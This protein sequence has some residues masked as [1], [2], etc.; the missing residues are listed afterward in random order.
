MIKNGYCFILLV[1]AICSINQGHAQAPPLIDKAEKLNQ[2]FSFE[3]LYLHSDKNFYLAGEII[4]F[5]IYQINGNT[6]KVAYAEILD[7]NNKPVLQAKIPLT[8][9]GGNG[10]FYLPL[11]IKS[12]YYTLRAYTNWMKNAGNEIFFEKKISI[13][14]TMKALPVSA[15]ANVMPKAEVVFFPESGHLIEGVETKVSFRITDPAGK[16]I[17]ASGV[18]RDN[19]GD[20]VAQFS[21]Y[22]FG[23]G[24][25][26]FRPLPGKTYK[27]SVL[28]PDGKFLE[29]P[30][31]VV[32]EYGY[33]MN[34]T[35]NKE[36]KLKIKI[37]ARTNK[38]IETGEQL[39]FLVHNNQS[40]RFLQQSYISY[41]NELL[42]DIDKQKLGEGI[43]YITLFNKDQQP[44]CERLVFVRPHS[45]RTAEINGDK[46]KYHTREPVDL[47]ISFKGARPNDLVNCSVSVYQL[48]SLQ[49]TDGINITT[50]LLLTEGLQGNI[51][52]P[53]YYLSDEAGVDE[54]TDNLLLT[55][56]WRRFKNENNPVAAKEKNLVFL[57]EYRGH[58]ITG[59]VVNIT[60]GNV[61]ANANCFLTTPSAPFGFHMSQSDST[62]IVR[63]DVKDYY[64][65]GEIIGQVVENDK[66]KYRIDFFNPF[67]DD[68]S[69][70]QLPGFTLSPE[71]RDQLL[72]KSISMQVQNIYRADSMRRFVAPD[73]PDTLP[74]FGKAEYVYKLDDYKR[75]TTMEEVLREYVFPINVVLRNGK[76]YMSI[77]DEIST[78]VYHDD[79]LVLLD[80]V[81]LQDYNKI[82]SFDPLKVKKLSVVPRRY[83]YGIGFFSGIA[84]FE[85]YN[86]KFGAF[87]LD[88][89][90]IAVDYE[91]LQMQREFYSPHYDVVNSSRI[92]DLRT[93]LYWTPEIQSDPLKKPGIH[94][95]TSDIK[96]KFMVV[97]EGLSNKGEPVVGSAV[98]EVQ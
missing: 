94:F 98:F 53:G 42:V 92:P 71:K 7:R 81:P 88:P 74:F 29:P 80:G 24:N 16:G 39:F 70:L 36:G 40:T 69:L 41:T 60:N 52:S 8:T 78:Q 14:N 25:F 5:K 51:E 37:Q 11:T 63:F 26:I 49:D 15:V 57:P 6:S 18:V 56:G 13:V 30:L 9:N 83:L 33:V 19:E 23:I 31:P 84:S 10:S 50:Y 27:A 68:P 66:E 54:A 64:G 43:N 65:P 17:N 76:L 28:L 46:Q 55:H 95:Y 96:G 72:D 93:T 85:T 48:D 89:S 58:F 67:S 3:K 12:D 34:V 61:V 22:R 90:L 4:W 91:G 97:L 86:A 87:D 32:E 75:F 20:T 44:V 82:F 45:I 1:L 73:L 62:G 47:S 59:R 35:D 21:S 2:L 79:I 77:Y 38:T